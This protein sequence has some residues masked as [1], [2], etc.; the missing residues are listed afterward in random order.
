MIEK[1]RK[2]ERE[3]DRGLGREQVR[4]IGGERECV[5]RKRDF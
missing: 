4:K 2:R 3:R 5:K 1:T